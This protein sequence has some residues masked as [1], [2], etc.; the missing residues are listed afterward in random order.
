[1]NCKRHSSNDEMNKRKVEEILF[2]LT[3]QACQTLRDYNWQASTISIKLRY[4][5]FVTHTRS[6]TI[7]PTDDDKKI[8]ETGLKLLRNV[9]TRRVATRLVGIH[10]SKF[11][12]YIYQEKIF[13]TEEEVRSKMLDAVSQLRSKFGYEI[14]KI[15]PA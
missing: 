5:D 7:T 2:R 13:K 10:L 11:N 4:S 9:Y 6:R 3:G 12:N 8:F 15:G 1:M 14:I